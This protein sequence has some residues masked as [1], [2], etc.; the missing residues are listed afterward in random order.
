LV[1]RSNHGRGEHR[2]IDEPEAVEEI[3]DPISGFMFGGETCLDQL[4]LNI[5]TCMTSD[6]FE[7][8]A[9]IRVAYRKD[10]E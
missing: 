10:D 7:R 8:S 5:V 6:A 3:V 4:S 2:L 1:H 9:V